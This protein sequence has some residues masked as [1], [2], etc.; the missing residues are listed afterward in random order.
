MN[1]NS[2]K[3]KEPIAASNVAASNDKVPSQEINQ[4]SEPKTK[5]ILDIATEEALNSNLDADKEKLEN[6]SKALYAKV[7]KDAIEKA[8]K[9]K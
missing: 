4:T 3:G 5:T 8:K 7:V 9:A 2:N 6:A 1:K